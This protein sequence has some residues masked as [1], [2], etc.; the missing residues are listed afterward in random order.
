MHIVIT[1]VDLMLLLRVFSRDEWIC[2]FQIQILSKIIFQNAVQ[3][4]IKQSM[5]T[6]AAFK[7]PLKTRF[8]ICVN[9][10]SLLH[11]T[12]D[13]I[14]FTPSCPPPHFTIKLRP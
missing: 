1:A 4:Y 10:T 5:I 11:G 12:D 7:T 3:S 8:G 14:G 6:S 2:V 13:D 9:K